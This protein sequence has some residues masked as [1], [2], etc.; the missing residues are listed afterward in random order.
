MRKVMTV[1]AAS[2]LV[3]VWT[4]SAVAADRDADFAK[5]LE[6]Y[7][8]RADVKKHKEAAKAVKDLA[9]AYPKDKEIQIFC[10]RTAY[11]C[12]HRLKADEKAKIAGW[13]V[14][15]TKRVLSEN[16]KDYDARYWWAR[17]SLKSRES[18]GIQAAI[19]QANIVQEFLAKLIKDEPGR[20]EGY[21][22]QGAVLREI[23]GF[24]GGDKKKALE[25]L[26]K[27]YAIAPRD[28][29]LLLELA[30]AYAVNGDKETARVMYDKCVEDSDKPKYLEWE[31]EDARAYAKKMKGKL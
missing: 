7:K 24:L 28:A 15:C 23:P 1:L 29:E 2:M 16:N 9:A 3:L 19:K 13:G 21:M 12:A 5:M 10:A 20:F 14:E 11:F 17:T 30:A 6:I 26:K 22:S 8:Q 18:E 25:V 27:G 31:T 4:T